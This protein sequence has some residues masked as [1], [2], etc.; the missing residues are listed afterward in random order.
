MLLVN[1]R[2]I[3][4]RSSGG[5]VNSE[6][7]NLTGV[8]QQPVTYPVFAKSVDCTNTTQK[9]FYLNEPICHLDSYFLCSYGDAAGTGGGIYSGTVSAKAEFITSSP[10]VFIESKAV[11]REQDLMVLNSRNTPPA[12]LIQN[13]LTPKKSAVKLVPESHEKSSLPEH[14]AEEW[15][16]VG[17]RDNSATYLVF[18]QTH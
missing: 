15:L 6:S 8:S 17:H 4:H 12:K 11:V 3:V 7:I 16:I 18:Q 14:K 9:F 1:G 13:N 5:I 2:T 10:N